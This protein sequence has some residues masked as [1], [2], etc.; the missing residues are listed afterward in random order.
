MW[1]PEQRQAVL[2]MQVAHVCHTCESSCSP[3]QS[4]RQSV[5]EMMSVWKCLVLPGV[6][7]TAVFL[8]PNKALIVLLLPTL[9]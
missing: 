4:H 7:A 2:R 3:G 6:G 8:A 9:G 1:K 5:C